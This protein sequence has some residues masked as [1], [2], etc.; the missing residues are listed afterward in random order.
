S[1]RRGG[2]TGGGGGSAS[3]AGQGWAIAAVVATAVAAAAWPE[4]NENW[5]GSGTS[6]SG[7]PKASEGRGRATTRLS[8][9]TGTCDSTLASSIAAPSRV[10]PAASTT[11]PTAIVVEASPRWVR[12]RITARSPAR[13]APARTPRAGGDPHSS[14]GPALR[15]TIARSP[16]GRESRPVLRVDARAPR[17]VRRGRAEYAR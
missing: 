15:T 14:R 10:S 4:G 7:R 5:S 16:T 6:A 9:W 11:R 8:S 12:R 3:G 13:R 2:P 17:R 1:A